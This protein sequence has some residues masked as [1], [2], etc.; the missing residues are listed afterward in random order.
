MKCMRIFITG[1]AGFIGYHVAKILN[2]Q[3]FEVA[4]LDNFNDY[5]DPKLKRQRANELICLGVK[6]E[7]LD[8]CDRELEASILRHQPTHLLHLAAQAGIRYSLINPLAY[9]KSNI[10]GFTHILELVRK[11]PS[12]T[13]TYASTSS[14][15]GLNQKLPYSVEERTDHQASFYGVTKKCNELMAANYVHLYGIRALGLRY[16]TVYGPWGRPDMALFKFTRAILAG[17]PIDLYNFGKMERDF[18]YIDDIV[19]GTVAALNYKGNTPIFNLGNHAP[20]SLL[21]FVEILE[22]A[23]GK[24]AVYNLLPLQPGEVLATYADIKE[25]Q[26]ELGFEPKTSLDEGVRR[27]VAWYLAFAKGGT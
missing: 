12:I 7:E 13:L 22:S 4:G 17:D 20:V 14:V 9:V 10:E 3:G 15:Y 11:H 27:F 25:S 18:T 16:F 26:K 5:Y 24:K 8:L 1:I 19:A 23:L 21:K 6:V 2:L